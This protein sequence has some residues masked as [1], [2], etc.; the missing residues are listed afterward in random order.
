MTNFSAIHDIFDAI[1]GIKRIFSNVFTLSWLSHLSN[2]KVFDYV[3]I[4]GL[5]ERQSAES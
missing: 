5:I 4:K 3:S 1:C 2:K